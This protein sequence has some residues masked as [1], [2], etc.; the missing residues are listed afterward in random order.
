MAYTKLWPIY[1]SLSSSGMIVS[2]V[3][4]YDKNEA[5]TVKP[6][7][8]IK[9]EKTF[10]SGEISNVINYTSNSVKTGEKKYVTTINCSEEMCIDEMLLTKRRYDEKGRRIMYHGV[11]SFKPGEID[12]DSPE[13]AHKL[14]IKLAKE[15]WG[16]RFEVVVTT[17]L[18]REHIHNHFAINSV[19]FKDGKKLDWDKEYKKM[20]EVS[21][22]LCKEHALSIIKESECS[23]HI[24]RGAMRADAEGRYTIESIVK[25]DIDIC[26]KCSKNLDEWLSLMKG[27]G[28]RID[29]SGKYL[30]IFPYRH[31]KCIRVDRRFLAKYGMDYSLSGIAEMIAD[32]LLD[33]GYEKPED[34][35]FSIPEEEESVGYIIEPVERVDN[36]EVFEFEY[37]NMIKP[38]RKFG[39]KIPRTVSGYQR[40]YNRYLILLGVHPAR[41]IRRNAR[42]HYLLRED[43]LK[44]DKYI[45]ENNLLISR[46]ITDA[47]TLGKVIKNEVKKL[48]EL[49]SARNK[50]RNK[51]RRA[52]EDERP[53]L[54]EKLEE[55]NIEI[56][57]QRKTVYYLKDIEKNIPEMKNKVE[58]ARN[59]SKELARYY[60]EIKPERAL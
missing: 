18:D 37:G 57:Q 51:I 30:K 22:R 3:I 40:V 5:K 25:E 36:E 43:L 34:D 56:K 1:G 38:F 28:Y 48:D 33:G 50:V 17:H 13:L 47:D 29:S 58:M 54:Y 8:T 14:G 59:L 12:K 16:D 41:S 44:L 7:N 55:M 27:K 42:T 60:G 21:D 53:E 46:D 15:L 32:N 26:I 23:G 6:N 20:R 9:T 31:S 19:S 35:M 2:K 24:H 45:A 52:K 10:S 11:Q 49:N 4:K 39:Y